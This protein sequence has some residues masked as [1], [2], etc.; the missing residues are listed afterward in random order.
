VSSERLITYSSLKVEDPRI[1]C[2]FGG[3]FGRV[4][5][6][7]GTMFELTTVQPRGSTKLVAYRAQRRV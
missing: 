1:A 2:D 5:S 7:A 4:L 3:S 6:N